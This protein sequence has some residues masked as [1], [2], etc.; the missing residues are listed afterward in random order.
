VTEDR[1]MWGSN[2]NS[3]HAENGHNSTIS[4]PFKTN[5][6]SN[7]REITSR[8]YSCQKRRN[9]GRLNEKNAKIRMPGVEPGA[10]RYLN[11]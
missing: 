3:N 8:I 4:D 6:G 1:Q 2:S 11:F 5:K 9:R 10:G 7:R